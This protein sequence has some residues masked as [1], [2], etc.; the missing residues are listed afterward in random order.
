MADATISLEAPRPWV[1]NQQLG[2]F[3][4][5]LDGR[6]VGVVMPQGSLE[7]SCPPGRHRV[8]A[9][10]W[11]NTGPVFEVELAEGETVRLTVDL[12]RRDSLLMRFL[13]LM[14]APWRGIAITPAA[15]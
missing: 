6:R 12:V 5:S 9:R 13:T 11:Y 15:G 7:V 10:Q 14:F 3:I 4:V 1:G 8:R 2:A